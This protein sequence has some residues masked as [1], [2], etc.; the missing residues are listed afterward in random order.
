MELSVVSRQKLV[1]ETTQRQLAKVT[2]DK[3]RYQIFFSSRIIKKQTIHDERYAYC[4][5][6]YLPF[7]E[8]RLSPTIMK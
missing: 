4:D 6:F 8:K 5:S 3:R 2:D 1:T 7:I